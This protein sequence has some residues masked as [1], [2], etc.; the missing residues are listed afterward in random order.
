MIV[1]RKKI[2]LGKIGISGTSIN[3][4]LGTNF[5]PMDNT[6]LIQDK[7]V[8]D[9]KEKSINPPIDYKKII[10]RPSDNN[11]DI[12]T[13]FK[14]NLNFYTPWTINTA[15]PQYRG[16]PTANEPGMY[17]DI[18]F[19]YDDLF[20]RTNKFIFSFL[21]F[22]FFDSPNSGTNSLLF[23]SDIYT[24]IGDDQKNASGYVLPPDECPITFTIGDP[25]LEPYMVHE[26]FHIYW[27]KDIVDN[28]P[29]KEY[30]IYMTAT[31]NNA[32]TGQSTRVSTSK[33]TDPSNIQII[34]LDGEDGILYLKVV[35]KND[36]GV[37]KYQFHPN[38]K[39]TPTQ[40]GV[41][42]NPTLGGMSN[43]IFWQITP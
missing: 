9:E 16:H 41:N 24:Q 26:A 42:L 3:I 14:L 25:V 12:I 6:E 10:F 20:C 30:E 43:I 5:F 34:D 23:Y 19:I 27:F 22:S 17:S 1:D 32:A 35:L 4:P 18:S 37:Y 28:A 2:L 21:R 38:V 13:K 33:V 40:G 8:D 7:F 36:N 15:S 29:N 11:W 39:Q 31:F